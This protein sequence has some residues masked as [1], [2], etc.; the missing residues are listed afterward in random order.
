MAKKKLNGIEFTRDEEDQ[1]KYTRE[2]DGK[3][4]SVFLKEA[5]T[6]NR[7]RRCTGKLNNGND[8]EVYLSGR[9]VIC[10]VCGIAKPEINKTDTAVTFRR[11]TTKNA[12]SDE[13]VKLITRLVLA[14]QLDKY[15][16]APKEAEPTAAEFA[17]AFKSNN[18]AELERL[19]SIQDD[20]EQY[21]EYSSINNKSLDRYKKVIDEVVGNKE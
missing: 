21:Q 19:A 2:V 16:V 11:A 12:I 6:N 20:W 18:T 14:Q 10:P 5:K 4:V 7:R 13:Q 8:C 3:T 15:P 1:D 9:T 17:S